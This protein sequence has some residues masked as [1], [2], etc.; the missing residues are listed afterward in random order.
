M[1]WFQRLRE[2]LTRTR[3][4]L[5]PATQQA[6]PAPVD[7]PRPL[8]RSLEELELA[9]VAADVGTSATAE[10]MSSLERSHQPLQEALKEALMEQLEPDRMRASLRKLG[11]K[12]QV[13]RTLVEPKGQVMM[14][15]G[16]NGVGKTTTIAKLAH[17]YQQAGRRV[18]LAACDTF[19]AAAR[20]QLALWAGRAEADMV[21]G[22]PGADPAALA[23]DAVQ[24]ARSRGRDLVIIDTAG[25]LHTK[26]NL[27]EEMK[28]VQRVIAKAQAG[29]PKEVWLVLDATTGQ[30]GLA[31]AR[32]FHEAL[33]LTGVVVTKLDGTAKGGIVV[34]IVRELKLP[35]KFIGVGEG[36]EDLRPFDAAEFVEALL[37]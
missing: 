34:S 10:I 19:R 26:F 23:F 13:A 3:Q 22:E 28:K 7:Q 32:A 18:L 29:E 31:Q 8:R 12:P 20:E 21:S 16:V 2:G 17:Y 36:L 5:A 1:S 6:E 33:Q 24:A 27:M 30:N 25:R 15:V 4:V 14:V 35:I 37:G 9:L 11:F